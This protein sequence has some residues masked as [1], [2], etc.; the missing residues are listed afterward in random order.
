MRAL[1]IGKSAAVL[2]AA[3]L[4]V[5]LGTGCATK[6]YVGQQISP[7]DAR[8]GTVEKKSADNA[9]AIGELE[10]NLS[11]TDERAMDAERKA[12]AAGQSATKANETAT[13]AMNRADQAN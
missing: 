8:L 13:M 12:V 6:K 9:S 11:K 7:I 4:F 1:I 2:G 3:L 10:N 5:T